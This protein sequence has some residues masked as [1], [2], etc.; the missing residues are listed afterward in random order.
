MG[1][2]L[3]NFPKQQNT[4]KQRSKKKE[5]GWQI[6]TTNKISLIKRWCWRKKKFRR[7]K[8]VKTTNGESSK[9]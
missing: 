3:A 1:N 8:A 6:F 2:S 4:S 5:K 9:K 7:L